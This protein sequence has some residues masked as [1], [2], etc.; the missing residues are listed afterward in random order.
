M[1]AT[2]RQS[3]ALYAVA[4]A[5]LR[6]VWPFLLTHNTCFQCAGRRSPVFGLALPHEQVHRDARQHCLVLCRWLNCA[7]GASICRH[8][9]HQCHLCYF[10]FGSVCRLCY[11]NRCTVDLEEGERVD[12]RNIL[13]WCMGECASSGCEMTSSRIR[14][15]VERTLRVCLHLLDGIHVDRFPLPDDETNGCSEHE[16]HRRRSWRCSRV[17]CRLVL[18]PCIR[19]C[20]LV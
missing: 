16:L 20:A 14:N 19:W 5:M 7:W 1:L 12:A 9:S 13:A 4:F 11:P 8:A 17:L 18:L 15:L 3:F 2:S 10:R 6:V